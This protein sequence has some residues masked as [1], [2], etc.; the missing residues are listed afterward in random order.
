MVKEIELAAGRQTVRHD[1]TDVKLLGVFPGSEA[2]DFEVA[3]LDGG[4]VKLSELRGKLVLL[5]FW[6]T[7]CG[8]CVAE[9]PNVRKAYEKF[10]AD[11]FVV[12]SISF[13]SDAETARRFARR[14][15]MTWPQVWVA[16]AD[17]SP[18]AKLYNVAGIPATFL[19]GPDG[20]VVARDLRGQRLI[21]TVEREVARLKQTQA[22]KAGAGG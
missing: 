3:T 12:I 16:G 14:N 13:D 21:A 11:G 15:R 4:K 20:K 2:P 8:P 6:A 19:V 5:D 7:W 10:G 1:I 18:L 9:L 17:R 22:A